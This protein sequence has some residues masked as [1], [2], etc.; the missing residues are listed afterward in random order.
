MNKMV[1]KNI[2]MQDYQRVAINFSPEI[3][4]LKKTQDKTKVNIRYCLIA[5]FAFAH[6]YWDPKIYELVYEIEEPLLNEEE[7]AY[8]E[9]IISAM[10]DMINFDS[11]IEKDKEK[12]IEYIDK[13]F[14]FLAIELGINLSYESYKKIYYYLCRDFMGFNETEPLLRD[15]FVEDIECNGAGGPVYIVHRIYRNIKT[16]LVFKDIIKLESFVEKLAQRC[17]KYISY[18]NP[19]LDGSLPDGSRVNATY[20]KDITSKGPTFTIR[21][22][23]KTPWTPIQLL[24]FDTL[25]PEML[26]YLWL[27]IQYKMNILISGGTASGKTTLLNAISFFI[28]PE[29]RV[30][31]IEDSVTGDSKIIIKENEKIKNITIKEFVDKKIDAEVMTLDEK[32]KIIFVKPSDYIR[33]IVKKDIYEILTSTGR[34]IKVTQDHA[35]FSLG[36]EGLTEIKPTELED[37]KSFI[38]VPRI[39]PIKGNKIKEMNLME[40]LSVF[41]EDFLQGEPLKSLFGKYSRFDLGVPKE[42]YRWWKKNNIIKIKEFMKLNIDF[43]YEE[44]KNLRIKSK[45]TSSIPVVFKINKE[46]LEFCGLWIGDGSYD[47]RNK[48]V[49]IISNQDKECR[50][51]FKIVAKYLG[52][53]YS[54]MND[55][56]VSLRLHSTVFYKLMK[57]VLGFDGYSKTKQIPPFI[58]NLSNEQIKHFIRGYFSADGTVKKYEVSC[59]SQSYS[60]L[61]DLQT[62]FLRLNIISRINDFNRKDK[63]INMSI[64]NSENIERFKEIGFLQERKHIKMSLLNKK[65]HH[66]CSDI[67]PLSIS[68]IN[69]LNEISE[70]RLSYPYLKG[71]QNIGRNYMQR[72]APVNSEFNDLSHSDILWDMVKS[73]GKVSSKEIEVFDLSIP[74]HEKFLCNNIFVHNTRELNLPRENWLPS[75][76]RTSTGLEKTGEIDLFMLLKSSFRQNPDYVIVGEVRG[77]EAYVL[78]QGMASGHASISTIHADS[79]DTVIKRLETPPIELSPTLLN[80]LDCVCIMTHAIVNKQETR[81]LKEIVEIINVTSNGIAMTNTPFVW[82]PSD[83]QFYFKRN[84]KI[85]EKIAKRYGL[86]IEELDLE[87][88][89][90][91]Q[92]IYRLNQ[93]KIFEF[94]KVQ[95]IINEY[96]KKPEEIL[97]KF[98]IK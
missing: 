29:A 60:L 90:R 59:S 22:F 30:V 35:L 42:R 19:I 26:A 39:L 48:N 80:V 61:E 87:F 40:N 23:T 66:T 8:K 73:V 34:K 14:K 49:V 76:V 43:S 75:V 6:I 58:F 4:P 15:Y 1:E 13:R 28:P 25:S 16:N 5:P 41:E 71:M 47:G 89:R 24:S 33:H 10:R 56:N 72:I 12:L 77:K 74:K 83:D 21:K 78:F 82:N 18:A 27:L 91:V 84:S 53:N 31:S 81:K 65:A 97:R 62:L 37:G 55:G 94:N 57:N 38:A 63:C 86:R 67:I 32:G 45:N 9:Q 88:R 50:G 17:G 95:E 96:V 68:R 44:L 52:S 36:K 11:I 69:E 70:T 98:G 93:N 3:P 92:L 2:G 7:T 51:I 79:V 46:F 85:L 64:S 20:T 54:A